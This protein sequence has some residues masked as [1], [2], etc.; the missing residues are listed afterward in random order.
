M[1]L[2]AHVII[3]ADLDKLLCS[4]MQRT[5]RFFNDELKDCRQTNIVIIRGFKQGNLPHT[6]QS[7]TDLTSSGIIS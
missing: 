1:N 7:S 6:S 2:V 3:I 4:E 5:E